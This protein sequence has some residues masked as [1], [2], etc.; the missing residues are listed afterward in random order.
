MDTELT[1]QLIEMLKDMRSS[2]S[3]AFQELVHQRVVLSAFGAITSVIVLALGLVLVALGYR[4]R[5]RAPK[6]DFDAENGAPILMV[7]GVAFAV[8]S[9]FFALHEAACCFAPLGGVLGKIQ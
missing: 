4:W 9:V 2:A 8:P 6:N 3:P 1:K 7:F 5:K